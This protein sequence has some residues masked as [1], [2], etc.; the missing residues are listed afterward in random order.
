MM[1]GG[2]GNGFL[3]KKTVATST[4][5]PE[6]ISLYMVCKKAVWIDKLIGDIVGQS[7]ERRTNLLRSDSDSGVKLSEKNS[8]NRRNKYI[9]ITYH[10]VRDTLE[11]KQVKL[12]YVPGSKMI[13]DMFKKHSGVF[14]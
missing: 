10:F 1:D 4:G 2:A 3:R 9:D 7:N 14:S 11:R 12:E 8:I 6:Y 13:S 5:E